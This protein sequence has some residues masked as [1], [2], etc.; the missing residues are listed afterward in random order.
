MPA[1]PPVDLSQQQRIPVAIPITLVMESEDFRLERHAST[2]DLSVR[3]VKVRT[4]SGLLPGETVGIITKGDSRQAISAH[5]VWAQ[6]V[7]TDVWSLAGLAFL[8][9]FP[10]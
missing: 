2:I 1:V 7:P 10:A 4:P 9:T 6:R 5:V 8:E 3:G